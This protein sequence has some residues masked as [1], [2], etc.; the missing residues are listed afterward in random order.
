MRDPTPNKI[1]ANKDTTVGTSS[2]LQKSRYYRS[3]LSDIWTAAYNNE[4]EEVQLYIEC[5]ANANAHSQYVAN[6]ESPLHDAAIGGHVE[7]IKLLV[8]EG[9]NI[10]ALDDTDNT[11]LH[12]AARF[13]QEDAAQLLLDLGAD[14]LL[15]NQDCLTPWQ[16][17]NRLGHNKI[18]DI[19]PAPSY[20]S[21]LATMVAGANMAKIR[22]AV[23]GNN[24]KNMFLDKIYV[25]K[26]PGKKKQQQLKA[27]KEKEMA[28]KKRKKEKKASLKKRASLK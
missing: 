20:Y 1:L 23:M 3:K 2:D 8:D 6:K 11:P 25:D 16:V 7:M 18:K 14:P 12:L 17:A 28:R 9:G 24:L 27:K 15:K 22:A 5:G 19:L 21:K 26:D 4:L 13:N 10:D